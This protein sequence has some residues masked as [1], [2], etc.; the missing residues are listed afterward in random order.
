MFRHALLSRYLLVAL[1][2]PL[3]GLA[4]ACETEARLGDVQ[5]QAC[6]GALYLGIANPNGS[7]Q[8]PVE[9]DA[10]PV[11]LETFWTDACNCYLL[12]VT[13]IGGAHT[14]VAH[15]YRIEKSKLSPIPGGQFGSEIG[16]ISRVSR[17]VGFVVE[18]RDGVV[19]GKRQVVRRYRFDGSKFVR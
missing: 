1:S 11:G 9:F 2:F 8:S 12:Q 5:I 6:G 13:G 19:T 3:N 18:V 15:F 10:V 4:A 7:L 16:K 14:R 17:E